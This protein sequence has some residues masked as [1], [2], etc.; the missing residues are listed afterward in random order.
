MT[1]VAELF[2][3][4]SADPSGVKK[5]A[6]EAV[7]HLKTVETASG[8]M[9]GTMTR[10]SAQMAAGMN[11]VRGSMTSVAAAA[12]QTAPGVAQLGSVIGSL[13]LGSTITVGVLAGLA[14]ITYAWQKLT[15]KTRETKKATEDAITAL[16]EMGLAAA[17]GPA[18]QTPA[19][20]A[21]AFREQDRLVEQRRQKQIQLDARREK[22]TRE[23]VIDWGEISGLTTDI[24]EIDSQLRNV[25][26]AINAGRARLA[27]I[28]KAAADARITAAEQAAQR[29]KTVADRA[30]AA[31]LQAMAEHAR[32][33][34]EMAKR[35]APVAAALDPTRDPFGPV[36][37]YSK[38]VA[39]G[40]VR[41]PNAPGQD[42]GL[43]S[44]GDAL[45]MLKDSALQV[46]SGF[47]PLSLLATAVGSALEVMQ[48]AIDAL[49]LPVRALGQL[50]GGVLNRA[51]SYL[52]EGIGYVI[53]AIGWLIDKI[54]IFGGDGGIGRFG[55]EM[56]DGARA[57]RQGLDGVATAADRAA[58]SITNMPEIF[59][60]ALRRR[61]AQLGS[62]PGA[63]P[64][65]GGGSTGGGITVHIHNPPA[66]LDTQRAARDVLRAVAEMKRRGGVTEFDLTLGAA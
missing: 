8:R 19:Q 7:R 58:S 13:A 33:L 54:N 43:T 24:A 21:A 10:N 31:E 61:Q 63:P 20:L 25:G 66:T 12:L 47:S 50:I 59:D 57:A 14:A 23:G 62:L 45:G 28:D 18:G 49:L 64:A 53:R 30:R 16:R 44:A 38:M 9:S 29:L 32:K 3:R 34:E 15:E 35:Q 51:I 41:V 65:S 27:E 2:V 46:V 11:A 22:N 42:A 1:N 17:L 48:P 26:A 60:L 52:A 37:D 36:A 40:G 56:I 4:M 39:V 5:G 55:Q 6:D